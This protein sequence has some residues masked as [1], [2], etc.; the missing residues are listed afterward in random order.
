[1]AILET[2]NLNYYYQDADTRRYIL[3][4]ANTSFEEG[5]FYVIL[6]Q[7]GSGKTTFLSLI[8]ALEQPKGG[9]IYYKG[10]DIT[11]IGMDNFRRNNI[12]MVFQSYNLIP[13]MTATENVLVA[14]DITENE[15]PKNKKEVASNLLDYIGLSKTKANRQVKRLSG[16]EQQRV[17]IARALSTNVD[18]ILADEPTGNL[19]EAMEMEIVEILKTLAH[20]H[21]KCVIV[22]THST[23]IADYA[24]EVLLLKKGELKA[25]E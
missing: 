9:N 21:H 18:I 23:E 11:Q 16:G 13:Y 12:G 7:S 2:K 14:M 17:A 4:D 15:L 3:K 1:M 20:E 10:K 22:V 6:G 24:D 5:K 25:Y 19:D 8:S